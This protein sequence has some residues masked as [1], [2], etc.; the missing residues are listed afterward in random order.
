MSKKFLVPID[1]TKNELQNAVFQRLASPPSSPE[2]GQ[3]YYDTGDDTVYVF[4]GAD[5]M[6]I[7]SDPSVDS[8]EVD[9]VSDVPGATVS[10]ALEALDGDIA[11]VETTVADHDTR[12]GAAEADIV[13]LQSDKADITYVDNLVQGLSWKEAVRVAS[14][15]NIDLTTALDD[16]S[17]VDGVTLATGDRVLVKNQT[18]PE[19]NGIYVVPA[20]GEASRS[21]DALDADEIEGMVVFV[22]EGTA[23]ADTSWVLSTNGPIVVDTTE[24]TFAQLNGGTVPQATTTTQGKVELATQAEAEARTDPD[25][26][27]TPASAVNFP[28]KK[29]FTIGNGSATQIDVTHNLGTKEVITQVRQASD[30]AVVE[31]DIT[32]FSTTVVRL[33]FT[34]AP[35]SNALKVVVM[36]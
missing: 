24:L 13:N 35:G 15:A 9:N 2:Q 18:D 1:L 30:D 19:Y 20:S 23:N 32:N 7:G 17:V 34:V 31:C 3:F 33:N 4:D 14:T 11:A 6:P 22:E 8:D 10:D 29:T 25:R 26:A 5:W 21:D 16:G 36:G 12:I 27:M 28:V